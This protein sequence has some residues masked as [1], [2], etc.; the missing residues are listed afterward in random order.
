MVFCYSSSDR[1]DT[2][3]LTG[4]L[5]RRKAEVTLAV[6][7]DPTSAVFST[8]NRSQPEWLGMLMPT[9]GLCAQSDGYCQPL[10]FHWWSPTLSWQAQSEWLCYISIPTTVKSVIIKVTL[11]SL[12]WFF[13]FF[14]G[15]GDWTQGS[16]M[17]NHPAHYNSFW[18]SESILL[19][20]VHS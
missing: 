18:F 15:T 20:N 11:V 13:F 17:L 9:R 3:L 14:G 19:P 16:C 5:V 6:N 10:G 7:S 2:N 1:Q 12:F 8:I 4:C